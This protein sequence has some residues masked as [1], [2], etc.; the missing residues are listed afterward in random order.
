[1][2]AALEQDWARA[3]ELAARALEGW[4]AVGNIWGIARALDNLAIATAR[5]GEPERA[6]P[7][8]REAVALA[9]ELRDSERFAH[10]LEDLAGVLLQL[11]RA[12]AAARLYGAVDQIRRDVGLPA[13]ALDSFYNRVD[14]A[15]DTLGERL[16]RDAWD[17]GQ[18]L[19]R[20]EAAAYAA[21]A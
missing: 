16:F 20:D 2:I 17:A 18:V 21:T 3:A 19:T 7:M 8:L 11:D 1:V 5:G 9:H 15:R 14:D 13:T 6:L 12:D 10:S 4:R